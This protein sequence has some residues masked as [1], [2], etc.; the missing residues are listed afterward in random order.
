MAG[1][2]VGLEGRFRVWHTHPEFGLLWEADLENGVT[3]QGATYL[4]ESVFRAGVVLT[5]WRIGAISE[6]GYTAVAT[7]DTY[8]A[9]AGWAEF[10]PLGTKRMLWTPGAAQGGRIAS[11]G[12]SRNTVLIDGTIRG[13]FLCDRKGPGDTDPSG[14]LYCTAVAGSGLAVVQGGTVYVTYTLRARPV[15]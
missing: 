3:V 5:D 10:V 12:V 4:L 1:T 11:A 9:H 2:G 14:T 7:T 8:V 15:S 13:M 6:A